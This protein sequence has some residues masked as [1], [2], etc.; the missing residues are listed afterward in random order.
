VSILCGS[1]V[2]SLVGFSVAK[3][4]TVEGLMPVLFCL[5]SISFLIVRQ[6]M[7]FAILIPC[8]ERD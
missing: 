8:L 6:N 2:G 7:F 5:D 1:F 4:L 3:F